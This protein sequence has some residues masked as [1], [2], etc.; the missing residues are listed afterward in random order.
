M[1]PKHAYLRTLGTA[2]ESMGLQGLFC[3]T[4]K[5]PFESSIHFPAASLPRDPTHF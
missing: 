4:V 3:L 5:L 2:G 1:V